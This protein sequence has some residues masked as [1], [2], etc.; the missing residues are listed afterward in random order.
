MEAAVRGRNGVPILERTIDLLAALERSE[1]G[2]SIRALTTRLSLPRSTV[3]RI[4]NTLE[5][6]D[7]VRRDGGGTYR[8]GTRL[9]ALA[10][11]V[12]SPGGSYDLPALAAPFMQRLV[13]A[14]G[15]PCKISVADG[16]MALVVAAMLGT[17]E[18]SPAPVV[19]T[20]YPLHA[21]A[22]SKVIMAH[23]PEADLERLLA[24]PLTRYTPHTVTDPAALRTQLRQIRR[25]GF[26]RDSG[27]HNASVHAVA[28][29]ILEPSGR[30]AGALSIPFLAGRDEATHRRL[31]DA[32]VA[33]AAE[34]SAALPG[35]RS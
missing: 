19:G 7:F 4:L 27:E 29:A 30:F 1:E 32:V 11:R 5:A 28:A 33:A 9:L 12:A 25:Q 21:G 10:R 26:A 22:A 31:R 13:E 15:E 35:G 34:I 3:Y 8:L 24:A 17:H 16:D 6:H 18:Y 20:R 14:T 2:E 23:L